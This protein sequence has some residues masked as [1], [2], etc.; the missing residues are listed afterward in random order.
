MMLRLNTCPIWKFRK[1]A[2]LNSDQINRF[3]DFMRKDFN[4]F[5]ED[6]LFY[7]IEKG[8]KEFQSILKN[9]IFIFP[10]QPMNKLDSITKEQIKSLYDAN[11]KSVQNLW[12][13][14]KINNNLSN[15][16]KKTGIEKDV[17]S[18][19][20]DIEDSNRVSVKK[21]IW[22]INNHLKMNLPS[23]SIVK[24]QDFIVRKEKRLNG[25]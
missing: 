18:K 22:S 19:W 20:V 1:I 8:K 12:T 17:L 15:I 3:R 5:N 7:S 2:H 23:D 24:K 4:F 6:D 9:N 25:F 13:E 11:I 16:Y 21:P 10:D 14:I